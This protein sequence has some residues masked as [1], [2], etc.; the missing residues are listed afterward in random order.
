MKVDYVGIQEECT[1]AVMDSCVKHKV[2]NDKWVEFMVAVMSG[3]S[4]GISSALGEIS[5]RLLEPDGPERISS[6]LSDSFRKMLLEDLR[7]VKRDIDGS[8]GPQG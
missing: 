7:E 4:K 8:Q 1:K 2:P 5:K 6:Y 3:Y